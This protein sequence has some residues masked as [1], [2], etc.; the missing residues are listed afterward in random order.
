MKK[1]IIIKFDKKDNCHF[2]NEFDNDIN[3][4]ILIIALLETL[5][6]ICK[7][8]NLDLKKQIKNYLELGSVDAYI[9]D[10]K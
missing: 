7:E 10:N 1:G 3:Y 9:G 4:N 5:N 8:Y 2:Q 6:D